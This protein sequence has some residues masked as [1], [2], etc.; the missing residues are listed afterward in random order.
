MTETLTYHGNYLRFSHFFEH[1]SLGMGSTSEGVGL[2][3]GSQIGLFI[4]QIC[5]SLLSATVSHLT[6]ASDSSGLAHGWVFGRFLL[7]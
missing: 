7:K 5:P 2:E 3:G 4:A 6:G 1:D